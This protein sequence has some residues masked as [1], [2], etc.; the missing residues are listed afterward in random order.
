LDGTLFASGTPAASSRLATCS[1]TT[2]A[3]FDAISARHEPL[4]PRR[5]RRTGGSDDGPTAASIFPPSRWAVGLRFATDRR[6]SVM[7]GPRRD[8]GAEPSNSA[9]LDLTTT[10][11]RP[12]DALRAS[13]LRDAA[14][15]LTPTIRAAPA[16]ELPQEWQ[17]T[18]V[19]SVAAGGISTAHMTRWQACLLGRG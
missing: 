10:D 14:H 11:E 9:A 2:T 19:S 13:R 3:R 12:W 18:R 4:P 17:T 7:I 8:R 5:V 1:P 16:A 6:G 15:G